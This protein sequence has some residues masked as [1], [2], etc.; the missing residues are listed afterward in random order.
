MTWV[1]ALCG[2]ALSFVVGRYVGLSKARAL[3]A[4]VREARARG[5]VPELRP[6]GVKLAVH[7]HYD[8]GVALRLEADGLSIIGSVPDNAS[9]PQVV[10]AFESMWGGLEDR[11]AGRPNIGDRMQLK[12]GR[13]GGVVTAMDTDARI[14]RFGD[15]STDHRWDDVEFVS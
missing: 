6:R 2:V 4:T 13:V 12:G 11:R 15:D 8:Q 7:A 1:L 3:A 5:L 14:V 9:V 10:A